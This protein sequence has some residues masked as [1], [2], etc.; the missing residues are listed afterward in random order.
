MHLN[1]P[2]KNLHKEE[3]EEDKQFCG[4]F[5]FSIS[6]CKWV[7]NQTNP[8]VGDGRIWPF[9]WWVFSPVL[10]YIWVSLT[11]SDPGSYR[12]HRCIRRRRRKGWFWEAEG[13]RR[14]RMSAVEESRIWSFGE[15]LWSG[16]PISSSIL[17]RNVAGRAKACAA[18]TA[19][20]CVIPGSFAATGRDVVASS[21][22]WVGFW[23]LFFFLVNCIFWDFCVCIYNLCWIVEFVHIVLMVF[24][25]LFSFHFLLFDIINCLVRRILL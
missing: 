5:F 23:F 19:P 21:E 12:R 3:E 6:L 16:V 13:R 10:W 14:R 4:W 18:E 2:N 11:P 24:V 8:K 9:S 22:R 20:A 25:F 17:Q 1:L 7:E 15:Q